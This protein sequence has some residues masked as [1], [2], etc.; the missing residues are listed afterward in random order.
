ME[1]DQISDITKLIFISQ[2][3]VNDINN[4][5]YITFFDITKSIL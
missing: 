1:Q 5:K 2:H 3:Q 4:H